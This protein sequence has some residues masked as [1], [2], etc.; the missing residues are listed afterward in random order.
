MFDK[1]YRVNALWTAI[2]A[3]QSWFVTRPKT[4]MRLDAVCARPIEAA[5]GDGFTI[6][7]DDEVKF[8]SK[9]DSKLPIRLR[10][11]IVRREDGKDIVLLTNDL[12]RS[13]VEIGALYK[14]RWRIELLF[15]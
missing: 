11:L 2:A 9:G 12:A 3:A 13:A 15:R 8:A 4:N 7:A 5:R 1:G 10:R 6:V 14:S